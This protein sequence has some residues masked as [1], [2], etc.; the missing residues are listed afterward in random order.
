MSTTPPHSLAEESQRPLFPHR[1]LDGLS[2]LGIRVKINLLL[3]VLGLIPPLASLLLLHQAGHDALQNALALYIAG[4]LLIFY[5][6]GRAMEELIVLRQ[7][8]RINTYVDEVKEG[9]RTAFFDLPPEKGEE[10]DF[11]RLQRNIFWMVQGLLN[12][13]TKLQ[14]TLRKL[15][16]AQRQVL[17]S[18]E[19]ASR[20]QR[21]FLPS[22]QD[23]KLALGD[24]F[25]FWLP[26]DGVGGDAY[27]V[28]RTC[29]HTFLAV[30]D[31]TGHGVPGAFLTLIVNSLF[32]Q[33][34]DV[35]CI[36]NPGRLL[37]KM[38]HGL[39]HALSQHGK[40]TLSDDGL[41]GAVCCLDHGEHVLHFAGA[42]SLLCLVSDDGVQEVKGDRSGVGFVHVPMDQKFANHAIPLAGSHT[43][44]LYTDGITDQIGGG[45]RLPF[46]RSRLHAWLKEHAHLPMETQMDKLEQ[47]FNRYKGRNAQRDDITVLGFS[48]KEE[49]DGISP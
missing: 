36:N 47:T 34:L 29:N 43:A 12:R 23:L 19:Y 15:E 39:K 7:T 40:D 2:N 3:L 1:I 26:R 38:N 11:L 17:E 46:G 49:Q 4:F 33:N 20:I 41:E 24:H 45:K 37:M 6:M 42:R 30:F 27:W 32:E 31:C 22:P 8:R 25:L 48:L 14:E 18:I 13:E 5:P 10:H 16:T 28:K 9:R 35:S 44:Y 21:S